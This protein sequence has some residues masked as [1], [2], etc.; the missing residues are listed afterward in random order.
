MFLYLKILELS[1][2]DVTAAAYSLLATQHFGHD[3]G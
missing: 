1:S 3:P 2:V